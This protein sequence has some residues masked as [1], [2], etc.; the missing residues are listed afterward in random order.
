MLNQEWSVRYFNK[1][2]S[3]GKHTVNFKKG[4]KNKEGEHGK[5]FKMC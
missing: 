5:R 4:K 1:V 3:A 2:N